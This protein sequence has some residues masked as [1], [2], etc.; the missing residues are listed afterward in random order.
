MTHILL[1]KISTISVL[2]PIV[3]CAWAITKRAE[4]Y[5]WLFLLF[6]LFGFFVDCVGWYQ[7]ASGSSVPHWDVL[8]RSY[9]LVEALFFFWL[10]SHT[11]ESSISRTARLTMYAII[12]F[13]LILEV[14]IPLGWLASLGGD[15][16]EIAYFQALYRTL[17][18]FLSGFALLQLAEK[19]TFHWAKPLPWFLFGILVYSLATFVMMLLQ[20]EGALAERFWYL[21]N[22]INLVTYILFSLGFVNHIKNGHRAISD[23]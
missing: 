16:T 18:A 8:R 19:D 23:N 6:L 11:A 3:L 13:W 22:V 1:A 14:F 9:A 12:P 7:Y 15:E 20:R 17:A 4:N 2:L 10:V 5:F 21:H